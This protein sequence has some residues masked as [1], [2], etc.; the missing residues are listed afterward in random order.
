MTDSHAPGNELSV[1]YADGT[2]VNRG[3]VVIYRQAPYVVLRFRTKDNK[4]RVDLCRLTDIQDEYAVLVHSASLKLDPKRMVVLI[5]YTRVGTW[6]NYRAGLGLNLDLLNRSIA[7]R[8]VTIRATSY[9]DEY[10]KFVEKIKTADTKKA[11]RYMRKIVAIEDKVIAQ[12]Y[13]GTF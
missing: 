13:R 1:K 12:L 4:K 11:K 6:S 10:N 7:A 5:R 8:L 3:D 2:R 9:K